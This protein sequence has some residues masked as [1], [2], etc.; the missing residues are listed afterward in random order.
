M[1]L[2]LSD[3]LAN[4]CLNPSANSPYMEEEVGFEP[5]DLLQPTVFKTVSLS[6]TQTLFHCLVPKVGLEPT[7][8]SLL[9]R[10]VYH[11]RHLGV[12]GNGG[13]RSPDLVRMKHLLCQLS[14]ITILKHTIFISL[15]A[16]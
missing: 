1:H 16:C 3:G 11:L 12:G 9:R 2:L 13:K 14:Y 7:T 4:R 5:T 15:R 8:F 6:Q 10:H